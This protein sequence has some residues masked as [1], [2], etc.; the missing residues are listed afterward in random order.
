MQ[1]WGTSQSSLEVLRA[2]MA[3]SMEVSGQGLSFRKMTPGKW[4]GQIQ[5][6]GRG[7]YTCA[8]EVGHPGEGGAAPSQRSVSQKAH[9]P[10]NPSFQTPD[11][12][13]ITR[14]F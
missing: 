2:R 4:G 8:R 6:R 3:G 10:D 12:A 11:K 5:G 13:Q 14:S 1:T 9:S 7:G